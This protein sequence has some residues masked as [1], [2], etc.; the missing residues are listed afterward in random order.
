MTIFG[1]LSQV[2][3]P[4]L[5]TA[6]VYF[7]RRH[8]LRGVEVVWAVRNAH[9]GDAFFDLDAAAF[10]FSE[11]ENDVCAGSG[12]ARLASLDSLVNMLNCCLSKTRQ[13][14]ELAGVPHVKLA[15]VCHSSTSVC[16]SPARS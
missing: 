6:S 8:A 13:Q 10:L 14:S 9:I 3:T 2:R 16:E 12:G 4:V 15:C 5:Q 11:I 7:M 1:E